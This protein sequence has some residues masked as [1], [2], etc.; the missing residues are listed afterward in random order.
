MK[1]PNCGY[2]LIEG[3]NFCQRC[4]FKLPVQDGGDVTSTTQT[5]TQAA[6]QQMDIISQIPDKRMGTAAPIHTTK[7]KFCKFCGGVIDTKTKKCTSCGKQ[8]FRLT[9]GIVAIMSLSIVLAALVGFNIYLCIG[10]RNSTSSI[11]ALSR[12]I[13]E[14]EATIS[15]LEDEVGALEAEKEET[16]SELDFYESY[17]VIVADDGTELYHA[18][19][20]DD[21]DIS[22]FWI[23]NID[24]AKNEGY[25][26]CPKCH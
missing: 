5:T 4:G 11:S 18:Y 16:A 2:E 25:E 21:L 26:P 17:A 20:C 13:I 1:C 19:G 14:K 15:A 8:F 10:L 7:K 6:G 23:Y 24:A 9:K 12:Q 3:F 22:S